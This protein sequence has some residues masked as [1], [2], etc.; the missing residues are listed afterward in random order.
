MK[1]ARGKNEPKVDSP[2]PLQQSTRRP[3]LRQSTR[4]PPFGS[5][6]VDGPT[7]WSPGIGSQTLAANPNLISNSNPSWDAPILLYESL[8]TLKSLKNNSKKLYRG[9]RSSKNDFR[10][11]SADHQFFRRRCANFLRIFG[12]L[13]IESRR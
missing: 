7:A 2:T 1:K 11:N 10:E 4:G 6:L 8:K 13:K 9:R 5:R 3:P 12:R